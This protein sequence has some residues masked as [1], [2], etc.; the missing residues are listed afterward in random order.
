MSEH[1]KF[2]FVGFKCREIEHIRLRGVAKA[3]GLNKSDTLRYLVS[4]AAQSLNITEDVPVAAAIREAVENGK[5][6]A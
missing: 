3:L 4:V 5:Q 2:D 1:T 6:P